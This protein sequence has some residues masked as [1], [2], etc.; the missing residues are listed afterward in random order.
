MYVFKNQK[1]DFYPSGVKGQE[2]TDFSLKCCWTNGA[3]GYRALRF[4]DKP[5]ASSFIFCIFE[6]ADIMKI[7]VLSA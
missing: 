6:T 1:T 4:R 5:E 3:I 2:A 7:E